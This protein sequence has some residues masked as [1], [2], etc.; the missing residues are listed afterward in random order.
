M[1]NDALFEFRRTACERNGKRV[2]VIETEHPSPGLFQT[3]AAK[4][5][6]FD[7]GF[8]SGLGIKQETSS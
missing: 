4:K 3:K 1:L 8:R 2:I 5:R 7:E 6:Y